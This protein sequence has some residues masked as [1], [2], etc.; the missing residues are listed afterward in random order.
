[1]DEKL[2]EADLNTIFDPCRQC[3]TCCKQYR[4]ISLQKDEIDFIKKMGGHVGVNV[5]LNEIREKGIDLAT[6]EAGRE[7]KIFM[8]HPDNKGC[9]F[10]EK[11]N[12]KYYCKIYH[13]RPQTC[14]GFRCNMVDDSML[15]LFGNDAI[16]LLGQ[17]SFG[18][19]LEQE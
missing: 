10:L 12:N 1:M 2:R 8:I 5:N 19:P 4:K 14:R 17:N 11:R 9:I 15:T 3:G 7:G 16:L 13:Y 6:E 18:L